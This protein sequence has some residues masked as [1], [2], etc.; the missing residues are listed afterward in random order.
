M[1][2]NKQ[3]ARNKKKA[4]AQAMD[5]IAPLEDLREMRAFTDR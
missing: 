1:K 4:P 3:A 5:T 2:K